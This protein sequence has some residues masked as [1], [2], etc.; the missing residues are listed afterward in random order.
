M[1]DASGCCDCSCSIRDFRLTSALRLLF[2]NSLFD[3]KV[4]CI[5]GLRGARYRNNAITCSR[6]ERSFLRYLNISARYMLNLNKAS[7]TGTFLFQSINVC[8]QYFWDIKGRRR[9]RCK[10]REMLR[11]KKS[12]FCLLIASQQQRKISD[13]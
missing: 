7:S 8:V 10:K 3:Q 5:N 6:R 1:Q 13:L 4:S 9:R 12:F 2:I 11:W